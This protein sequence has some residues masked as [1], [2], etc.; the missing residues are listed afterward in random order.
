MLKNAH[1]PRIG[2][3][4][5]GKVPSRAT[6]VHFEERDD[7][8]AIESKGV[9]MIG[10]KG[11]DTISRREWMRLVR[12][13]IR[14]AQARKI[15]HVAM[16]A[17]ELRKGAFSKVGES[18]FCFA[19][20]TNA[21]IATYE[22]RSYKTAPKEGWRQ[23]RE[24]YIIGAFSPDGRR[25]LDQGFLVG[26]ET[27]A[28]R[29]LA[30]TPAGDMTPTNLAAAART[31]CKG[32]PVTT[33]VLGEREMK[34]LGMGA[35][36][37]VSRGSTEDAQLIILEYRGGAKDE[38]PIAIVGKGITFD[39][40]GINIK[41]SHGG[42]LEEMHMDMSGGAAVIHAVA[43]AAR[44]KLKRNV[45]GIVAAAEN[46][47]SGSSYRPGDILHSMSGKTIEVLNTDAE[48]RL[49]LSD[50]LTYVQKKFSPR[51]V[52]DVATLTGAAAVALGTYASAV[53]SRDEKLSQRV[54]DLG[55]RSGDLAWPLPLAPELNAT[56]KSNRADIANIATVSPRY[57]GTIEGAV[58]LAHFVEEKTPWVHID[59]V[60]RM[61]AAPG[62]N[63]ADGA[64][65][66]P[67]RLLVE[68]IREL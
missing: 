65:G 45:V 44:L 20:A 60:P 67:V 27:N 28:A 33:K 1:V 23:V 34:K 22:F 16:L 62:D 4:V 42:S 18:D 11:L 48:G 43:A 35:L 26:H 17:H 24:L 15:T 61:I 32:L 46:M 19:L 6:T 59:I 58:F 57:G 40:G 30:N 31:A 2:I 52:I 41:P 14:E 53:L 8:R 25:A 37:G 21:A 12:R 54:R 13:G 9:L 56:I 10:Y 49:V 29:E 47:V 7:D 55:D 38:R 50:A 66:E 36:L 68:C 3:E 5:A 51:L 64:T 39:S 63:L